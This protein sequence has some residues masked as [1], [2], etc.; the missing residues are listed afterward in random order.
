MTWVKL[1]DR[2]PDEPAVAALSDA[3]FRLHVTALCYSSRHLTDGSVP[4][5]M[6]G[7]WGVRGAQRAANELVEAGLWRWQNS[8][9]W[10]IVG[11]LDLQRSRAEAEALSEKRA[12]AGKRG[13]KAK[14]AAKQAAG[15]LPDKS[16][17]EVEGR[18]QSPESSSSSTSSVTVSGIGKDDDEDVWFEYAVL[19]ARANPT[20]V[21]NFTNWSKTV[22]ADG[23]TQLGGALAEATE[24]WPNASNAQLAR[25]LFDGTKPPQAR[26]FFCGKCLE[27]HAGACEIEVPS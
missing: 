2:L 9:D 23:Q 26:V 15:K 13:G 5:A 10:S 17:A 4:D 24:K 27:N 16:E 12:E 1:D 22:I 18:V 20:P 7:R 3:A 8:G 19:K 21:G 25:F 14:A 6:I 11:Y